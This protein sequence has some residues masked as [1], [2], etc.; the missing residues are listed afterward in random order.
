MFKKLEIWEVQPTYMRLQFVDRSITKLEGKIEDVLV[1]VNKFLFPADFVILDYEADREVPIILGQLFLLT[2]TTRNQ[3]F[4]DA[5]EDV[6]TKNVG[7]KDTLNAGQTSR[8]SRI[9]E[10]S[11]LDATHNA[12][13]VAL[14]KRGKGEE[15]NEDSSPSIAVSPPSATLAIMSLS[16][17]CNNFTETYVQRTIVIRKPTMRC[18]T[19]K[20][21]LKMKCP[22]P[23]GLPA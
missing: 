8:E 10:N 3:G 17:L 21:S 19:L 4:P 6:D 2:S 1:K 15:R 14:G 22:P 20:N 13:G 18:S 23:L 7:N 11:I 5:K 12:S 9:E 16:Y